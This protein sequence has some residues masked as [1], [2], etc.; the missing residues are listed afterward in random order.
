[1]SDDTIGSITRALLKVPQR[2]H[3]IILDAMNKLGGETSDE[4]ARN[5]GKALKKPCAPPATIIHVK[6][7]VELTYP[8]W[9][10]KLL[11]PELEHTG[12][13]TYK[14]TEL[15]MWL[16]DRQ[17]RNHFGQGRSIYHHLETNEMLHSCLGLADGLALKEK[18]VE[19]FKEHFSG[20]VLMLWRSAVIK[21][22][23]GYRDRL[24]IP[25]LHLNHERDKEEI[26]IF[27]HDEFNCYG[28]DVTPL[29]RR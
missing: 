16:H 12:P 9:M 21:S 20:R 28:F 3:G 2:H 29:F 17:K 6:R 8:S 1:M 11:H 14:V 25:C 10:T 15:E 13:T 26:E 23:E 5:L 18:G 4:V 24:L 22:E 19:F 27:W 7:E